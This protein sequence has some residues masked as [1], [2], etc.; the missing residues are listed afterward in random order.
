MDCCAPPL[1]LNPALALAVQHVHE[2]PLAMLQ[3]NGLAAIELNPVL[4]PPKLLVPRSTTGHRKQAGRTREN[5]HVRSYS[6]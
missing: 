4:A 3:Q 6:G 5:K 1:A 2:R